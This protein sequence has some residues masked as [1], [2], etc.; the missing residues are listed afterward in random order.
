MI[1]CPTNYEKC[2]LKPG[3]VECGNGECSF[4]GIVTYGTE[5]CDHQHN[6]R[7]LNHLDKKVEKT[8]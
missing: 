7:C 6:A 8:Y 3:S 1:L 5:N 2:P 4:Q